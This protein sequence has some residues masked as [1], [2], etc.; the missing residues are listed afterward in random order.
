MFEEN[1]IYIKEIDYYKRI[2]L[3]INIS[4]EESDIILLYNDNNKKH[5]S[6]NELIGNS[7]YKEL[8]KKLN[9]F[10][11]KL[12]ILKEQYNDAKNALNKESSF[13]KN[14]ISDYNSCPFYI[15]YSI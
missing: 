2:K 11:E 9:N 8:R 5:L 15:S 14:S 10:E 12:N 3:K 13:V 4:K 1:K 7:V 6:K